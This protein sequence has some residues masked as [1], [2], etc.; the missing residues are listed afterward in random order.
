V[1]RGTPETPEF[2]DTL[3]CVVLQTEHERPIGQRPQP[4]RRH[5]DDALV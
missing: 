4:S 5:C 3:V 2:F 1:Q